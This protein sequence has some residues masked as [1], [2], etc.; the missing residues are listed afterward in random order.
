M[1]AI[2]S[3]CRLQPHSPLGDAHGIILFIVAL[4]PLLLQLLPS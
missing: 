2:Y 1:R 4:I 3:D